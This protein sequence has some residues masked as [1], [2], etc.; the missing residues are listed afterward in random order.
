MENR[1]LEKDDKGRNTGQNTKVNKNMY[2]AAM[3]CV[4]ANTDISQTF[5]SEVGVKRGDNLSPLLLALF[6]NDIEDFIKMK[7]AIPIHIKSK[8]DYIYI[9][10]N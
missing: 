4:R 1:T 10:E 3:C 8:N 2:D 6:L 9:S 5:K 7:G